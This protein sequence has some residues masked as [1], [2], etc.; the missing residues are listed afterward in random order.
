MFLVF[1]NNWLEEVISKKLSF[2]HETQTTDSEKDTVDK[3]QCENK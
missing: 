1:K 3:G 2:F